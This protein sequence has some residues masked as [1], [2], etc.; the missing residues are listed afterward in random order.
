MRPE[1]S[2]RHALLVVL[3]ATLAGCATSDGSGMKKESAESKREDAARV[4]TDLGQQYMRQGN[5]ELALEKL[6]RALEFDP[7]YVDAHTVIAVLYETIGDSVQAGVH[8]K[9]AAELKPKAGA[10][11]NNYGW[12]L[13]RSGKFVES[14]AYFERALADPFYKTPS[15]ALSNSGTCL[16]KAGRRDE[17]ENALRRALALDP[18]DA[19]ALLQLGSVLYDK[20]EF[21]NAR[22]FVQRH[23]GLSSPR[24]DALLLGRNV[25]LR[26]GNGDAAREYTR[27]LLQ[28]F[29]DSEQARL[30]NAQD[31]Q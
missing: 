2:S 15:L 27:R 13:C 3:L 22:A 12:Y 10:V 9:R 8:Y 11:N 24:P 6:N 16:L 4:N 26:L 1:R 14:Q 18:N 29:P 25:E 21:F 30:L 5:L 19:E 23:E 7:G 31:R 20:G 28:S 17:A